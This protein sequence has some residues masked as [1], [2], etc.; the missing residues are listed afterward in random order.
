MDVTAATFSTDVVAVSHERPVV[1]DF[2]APWCGP[3]RTLG[4]I[5]EEL[6]REGA[7]GWTLAKIDTDQEQALA[8]QFDI[9]GIP[10]V[11]A[12]VDGEVVAEFTGAKPAHE[13]RAWLADLAGVPALKAVAA[14]GDV[15]RARELLGTL[16]AEARSK[17]AGL[18]AQLELQAQAAGVDVDALQSRVEAGE[19][20]ARQPLGAALAAAGDWEGAFEQWLALVAAGGAHKEPARQALLAGFE[21]VGS[22]P[23]RDK[24]QRRLMMLLF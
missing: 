9:R 1:V 12:F 15:E 24:A 10:A 11:K 18:V 20:E 5:L 22:G 17:L 8:R 19:L 3:C 16:S 7:G 13:V 2:W 23:V 21:A 4:P 14:A 6:E